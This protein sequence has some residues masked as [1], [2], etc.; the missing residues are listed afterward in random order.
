MKKLL[1]FILILIIHSLPTFASSPNGKGLI[2]QCVSIEK[3]PKKNNQFWDTYVLSDGTPSEIAISFQNNVAIYYYIR[4]INDKVEFIKEE[5]G[6]YNAKYRFFTTKGTIEWKT[7]KW[8]TTTIYRQTL[9]YISSNKYR[10]SSQNTT[11]YRKC[12]VYNKHKLL[13]NFNNLV[14]KYQKMHNESLKGNLI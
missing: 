11:Y 6:A 5:L 4:I 3:C 2:C 13:E 1:T 14:N 9:S 8:N 10:D 12:K 7:S